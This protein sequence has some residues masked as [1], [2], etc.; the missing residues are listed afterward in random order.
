MRSNAVVM[1]IHSAKTRLRCRSSSG[2]TQSRPSRRAVPI[3]RSQW[4]FACGA[5]TGVCNTSSPWLLRWAGNVRELERMIEG[6]IATCDDGE[7]VLD[8]LPIAPRCVR[9]GADALRA[10][11]RYDAAGTVVTAV[12]ENAHTRCVQQE[13][14]DVIVRATPGSSGRQSHQIWNDAEYDEAAWLGMKKLQSSKFG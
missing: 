4:A 11:E 13:A 14:T 2:I 10:G 6:A 5:V 7:I 1:R 12:D 8:Y 3:R 9:G